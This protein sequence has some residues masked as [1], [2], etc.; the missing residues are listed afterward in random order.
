MIRKGTLTLDEA[1]ADLL[2]SPQQLRNIEQIEGAN[3]RVI[4]LQREL[5]WR[6]LERLLAVDP[7]RSPAT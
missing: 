4:V 2:V 6:E 3:V 7:P 5:T 1:R